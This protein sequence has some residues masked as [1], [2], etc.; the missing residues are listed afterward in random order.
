MSI[1]GLNL[2]FAFLF[3]FQ[4]RPSI[5]PIADAIKLIPRD[6]TVVNTN[7]TMTVTGV[8]TTPSPTP[9]SSLGS[10]IQDNTGGI[11]LFSLNY[12][13]VPPRLGDSVVATGKLGLFRGQ[14][15]L[16]DPEI[17][18]LKSGVK[19]TPIPVTP[20]QVASGEYE[21]R[22]VGV[23]GTVLSK[24]QRPN[25]TSIL[26]RG[27]GGDTVVLYSE[28]YA[29]S[30]YVI[31]HIRRADLLMV[32][33]VMTRY[34]MSKPYL[35]GNEVYLRFPSDIVPLGQDFFARYSSDIIIAAVFAAAILIILLVFNY[36][37]R[38]EI[39]QKTQRLEE[40]GKLSAVLYDSIAEL[41]GLLDRNE[42]VERIIKGL[43]PHIGITSIIFF[44][45]SDSN[46]GWTLYTFKLADNQVEPGI[47]V[48]RGGALAGA[49]DRSVLGDAS[50]NI[51]IGEF[52]SGQGNFS[53]EDMGVLNFLADFFEGKNVSVV[54]PPEDTLG[55][56]ILF[57]HTVPFTERIQQESVLSYIRH[58]LAAVRGAEL[59]ALSQRQELA[60]EKLYN[61]SVFGLLT[62]SL[63]GTIKTANIVASG[64]LNDKA[65]VGKKVQD[66]LFPDDARR[67]DELLP[68]LAAEGTEKFV[69]F[70]AKIRRVP[71]TSPEVEFA[72]E[73]D[74]EF[75]IFNVSVQDIGD[76]RAFEDY[77][78]YEQ[79]IGT[80][81]KM[82]SFLS[83]DLNNIVGSITGYASLL[84]RKLPA[85]S[86][87]HHYADIIEDAGRRTTELV[88]QVL[89]FAQMDAKTI[90][91]VDLNEFLKNTAEEFQKTHS[92]KY[93]L[94]TECAEQPIYSRISTSQFRQVLFALLE[95]AAEAMEDGGTI[96]CTAGFSDLQGGHAV[97]SPG[98]RRCFVEIED[99]G[100]GM[101]EA[102]RRRIFEPFFTTKRIKKYT[103]L[104]LSAAFNIVKHHKG[105]ISVDS[106]PGAGT[107][108][109]IYLPRYS[110]QERPR[111]E[112]PSSEFIDAT[113][114]KILVVDDEKSVRQLALDI[115]TEQGFTVV[116]GNDGR[117][118]LERLKENPDVRLVV[119][120]M[121]MPVMGGKEACIAIKKL[122]TPPKV[123]ICTGFSELSDL[124]TILGS[125]ADGL[126]QK[127][128]RTADLLKMVSSILRNGSD[129][130]HGPTVQ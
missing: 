96:R 43:N 63:D 75:K 17:R 86:K 72:V 64:L 69:R 89:G 100:V 81:E 103:G 13:G 87:E 1:S 73:F 57:D 94:A 61:S 41:S 118:A 114:V 15:E 125:Y 36:L 108:V 26:I 60:I 34:T 126:L 16:L 33:G 35:D 106:R 52:V 55:S 9:V 120:D 58:L 23:K 14:E 71:D 104:S 11:K 8:V 30:S 128:Y 67:L 19:V 44:L 78:A 117:E 102:I 22:L 53:D 124:E 109:R 18:I 12:A 51:P 91:V 47:K 40:Q 2:L 5:T 24:E 20:A 66:F 25:G 62:L 85:E 29:V 76:R 65:P 93:I 119:L 49:T 130:R 127:P 27:S 92:E 129:R 112:T 50:W 45:S 101:D 116:T 54:R 99:H 56:L 77:T 98:G 68:S 48:F 82:A 121:V 97:S 105:F 6:S 74:A 115:L 70:E 84:K 107:K 10:Y 3:L 59:F 37:L 95:N 38:R 28:N 113:G 79:K 90:E 80:L 83:H 7:I 88:K 123:L 42:I 122:P 111:I 21:G 4:T 110:D 39:R 32:T 46:R 31:S